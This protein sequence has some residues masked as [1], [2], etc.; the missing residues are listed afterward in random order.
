MCVK[1]RYNM[2]LDFVADVVA[3]NVK[4]PIKTL[5]QGEAY[6]LNSYYIELILNAAIYM[7]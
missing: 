6:F 4:M 7:I 5:L 1:E 2:Y 3:I